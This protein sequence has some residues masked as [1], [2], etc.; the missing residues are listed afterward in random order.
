MA[1]LIWSAILSG[2]PSV[3]D[4]EVNRRAVIGQALPGGLIGHLRPGVLGE[5]LCGVRPESDHAVPDGVCNLS[6]GARVR[7]VDDAVRGE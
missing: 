7:A 1:S 5:I 3:T 4:S 6:L 2:C